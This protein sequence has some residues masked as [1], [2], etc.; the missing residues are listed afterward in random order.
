VHVLLEDTSVGVD[1]LGISISMVD[2]TSRWQS[3]PKINITLPTVDFLTVSV[4]GSVGRVVVDALD[5]GALLVEN[6]ALVLLELL[7]QTGLHFL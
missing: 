7:G 1:D 6:S 2:A 3:R 4:M 5:K